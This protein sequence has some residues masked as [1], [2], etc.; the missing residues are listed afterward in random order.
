MVWVLER[1]LRTPVFSEAQP[2]YLNAASVEIP[3]VAVEAVRKETLHLLTN[4]FE[5]LAHGIGL[6][7]RELLSA[8]P[9]PVLVQRRGRPPVIDI[10][11]R[12]ERTVKPLFGAIVEFISAVHPDAGSGRMDDLYALRSCCRNIVEA[13]KGV[14]HLNKNLSRHMHSS[15]EHVRHQY[16]RIRIELGEVLRQVAVLQSDPSDVVTILSSDDVKL[17]L[18]ELDTQI[19]ADLAEQIRGRRI[20]ASVVTSIMNDAHYARELGMDL[21]DVMQVLSSIG[22]SSRRAALSQVALDPSE[23]REMMSSEEQGRRA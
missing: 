21:I 18:A 6:H 15:N 5:I 2:V 10:D 12:Y 14:K 9:L 7:R 8:D 4:A 3:E 11:A 22:D 23:L 19:M 20:P 13:V 16:D 1:V 17:R